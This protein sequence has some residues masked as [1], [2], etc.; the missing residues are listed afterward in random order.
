[1]QR[2]VMVVGELIDILS[3][4]Q[5]YLHRK[6]ERHMETVVRY[7]EHVC[8]CCV[9]KVVEDMPAWASCFLFP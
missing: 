8:V 7:N 6:L 5:T 2:N 3:G 4:E 1:V 9:W